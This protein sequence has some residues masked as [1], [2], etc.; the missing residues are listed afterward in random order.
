MHVLKP[1]ARFTLMASLAAA[2]AAC[3]SD[4]N[5]NAGSDTTRPEVTP[6][7]ASLV[8]ADV[9]LNDVAAAKQVI[10]AEP[11]NMAIPALI[12]AILDPSKQT[13]ADLVAPI[14]ALQAKSTSQFCEL[15]L[16]ISHL[17]AADDMGVL[18]P[19]VMSLNSVVVGL[20]KGMTP[21]QVANGLASFLALGKPG[22]PAATG[23]QGLIT[24]LNGV[25]N[26]V[27]GGSILSPVN[28]LLNVLLNPKQG[29]LS[30]LTG[31]VDQLTDKESGALGALTGL[32]DQLLNTQ[33][34]ALNPLITLL[35]G[36]LGG[37]ES[38]QTSEEIAQGILA[39]ANGQL[40][41]QSIVSM[42]PFFGEALAALAPVAPPQSKPSVTQTSP[43]ATP[44][45]GGAGGVLGGLTGG[46]TG[47]S[48]AGVPTAPSIPVVGELV[49]QIPVLGPLLNQLLGGLLGG[50][51]GG[52]TQR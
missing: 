38:G 13:Q 24:S 49:G 29:V 11:F 34:Q 39:L 35:N 6:P 47:S 44:S 43:I 33:D 51:F 42:V 31:L 8:C 10:M 7:A 4:G 19:L 9:L 14:K 26:T 18:S 5:G 36:I 46:L 45:T 2:V 50:L 3:G 20:N 48:T 37:T 40:F 16:F 23:T 1:V 28:D 21:E 41:T 17:T 25:T 15:S 30:P 32:V 22:T 12:Q 52:L 27:L